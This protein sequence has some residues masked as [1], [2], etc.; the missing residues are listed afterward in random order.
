MPTEPQPV[1][2]AQVVRRAVDVCELVEQD[3]RLGELLERFEDAD[4]PV[5]S[6]EDVRLLLDE[7]LG[8]IDA[9]WEEVP[10]LAM[11]EAVAAYLA[12]RPDELNVQPA[13]LLRLSA[14]A[15]FDGAPAPPVAEWLRAAGVEL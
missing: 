6:V 13:E 14:R 3:E 4:E 9:D 1:S 15:E 11:A 8:T 5:R 10:P 12:F 7:T 2:L